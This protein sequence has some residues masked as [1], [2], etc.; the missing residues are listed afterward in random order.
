MVRSAQFQDALALLTAWVRA[1]PPRA[2]AH[3]TQAPRPWIAA[4]LHK[5]HGRLLKECRIFT[6][7]PEDRQHAVR[8]R[9][10]RLRYLCE[11]VAPLFPRRKVD[12]FLAGLEPMQDALGL[13]NDELMAWRACTALAARD[14]NAWF[15][16]GWLSARRQAH[17]HASA[18]AL[19]A[20]SR[21]RPFWS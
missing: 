18:E 8:K 10:K 11:F 6:S 21:L 14:P 16:A 19:K 4:R 12:A 13:Y 17:L 2:D 1:G 15:G 9:I 7:L 20:F 3:V 5:L